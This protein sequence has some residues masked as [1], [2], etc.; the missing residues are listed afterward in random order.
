MPSKSATA[1]TAARPLSAS[2]RKSL[3]TEQYL[4][5]ISATDKDAALTAAIEVVNEWLAWDA[6]LSPT[7]A[8]ALH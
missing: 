4:T 3:A 7:A 6:E 2:K 8:R 5:A 1:K